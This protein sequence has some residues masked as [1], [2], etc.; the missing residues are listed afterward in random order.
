VKQLTKVAH[1]P[2]RLA[3]FFERFAR[4]KIHLTTFDWDGERPS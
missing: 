1:V 2:G 4:P 3:E